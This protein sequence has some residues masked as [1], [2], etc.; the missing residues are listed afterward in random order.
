MIEYLPGTVLPY[1][2]G[3]T[4]AFSAFRPLISAAG[5]LSLSQLCALTG[6]EGSTIQNWVKRGWVSKPIN[7]KYDQQHLPRILLLAALRENIQI[8]QLISVI[9]AVTQTRRSKESSFV[10]EEQVIDETL[11]YD[12]L[13]EAVRGLRP[14]EN[15]GLEEL[16]RRICKIAQNLSHENE[17]LARRLERALMAM[18][19]WYLAGL[20]RHRAGEIIREI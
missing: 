14:V 5:G 11:L 10:V 2:S 13:C 19:Y 4:S 15:G 18:S 9:E 3:I 17:D 20:L 12:A 8:D 6:L 1:R 7:K 16:H